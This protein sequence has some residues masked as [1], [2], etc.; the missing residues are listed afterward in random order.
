M[1]IEEDEEQWTKVKMIKSSG[2]FKPML[3]LQVGETT[4]YATSRLKLYYN[5]FIPR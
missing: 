1:E 5:Y 3:K 4:S 2:S